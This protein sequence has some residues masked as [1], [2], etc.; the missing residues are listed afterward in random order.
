MDVVM[1]NTAASLA[2]SPQTILVVLMMNS[3]V[4]VG[5]METDTPALMLTMMESLK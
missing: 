4:T 2:N 3:F 1:V 5:L